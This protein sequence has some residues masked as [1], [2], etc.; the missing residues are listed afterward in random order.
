MPLT[1][2]HSKSTAVRRCRQR[3][4]SWAYRGMALGQVG[5]RPSS[6]PTGKLGATTTIVPFSFISC[7]EVRLRRPSAR[8]ASAPKNMSKKHLISKGTPLVVDVAPISGEAKGEMP[9]PIPEIPL[10]SLDVLV[11]GK[12]MPATSAIRIALVD[13]EQLVRTADG[14]KE[15]LSQLSRLLYVC[16]VVTRGALDCY[17]VPGEHKGLEELGQHLD[18]AKELAALCQKGRLAR[19]SNSS[20]KALR[21]IDACRMNVVT[22]AKAHTPELAITEEVYVSGHRGCLV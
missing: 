5:Q 16:D 19:F 3:S 18:R 13:L 2:N 17:E 15:T 12:E 6:S 11:D 14:T 20:R 1:H 10:R 9:P 8:I 22:F 4:K 21:N 7:L